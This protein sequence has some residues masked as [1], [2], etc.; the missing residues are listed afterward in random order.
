MAVILWGMESLDV[1][2]LDGKTK[3]AT[4]PA[5]RCRRLGT[6]LGQAEHLARMHGSRYEARRLWIKLAG[7][8][9]DLF[10]EDREE[11]GALL[12][13][14]P[15]AGSVTRVVAILRLHL[16][17][18]QGAA[19]HTQLRAWKDRLQN[20]DKKL[21]EWLR[22]PGVRPALA[23]NREGV[24]TANISQQLMQLWPLGYQC[25][26][27]TGTSLLVS[28]CFCSV[29]RP[30]Y[31]VRP[32]SGKD[33]WVMQPSSPG[34]DNRCPCMANRL[35]ALLGTIERS[36]KWPSSLLEGSTSLLPNPGSDSFRPI[37]VLSVVY[38]LWSKSRL[39]VVVPWLTAWKPDGIYGAGPGA[40]ADVLGMEVA[41]DV[42]CKNFLTAG[43]ELK[44]ATALN[45]T[46]LNDWRA[47]AD[48][49]RH[50]PV[51]WRQKVLALL[52]KQGQFT[53]GQGTHSLAYS[54]AELNK[55]RSAI[56][57]EESPNP[58]S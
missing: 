16:H 52:S 57:F 19:S 39:E 54:D 8:R 42:E 58:A 26:R 35:A 25:F 5:L 17:R 56:D 24:L 14:A 49:A 34:L 21:F 37:S 22:G 3:Q 38:R 1:D 9:T 41:L 28:L 15:C 31:A 43:D 53:W 51:A 48:R 10:V 44:H 30:T 27:S 29:S 55:V 7:V 32:W 20:S 46:R 33:G 4:A 6:A 18:A 11:Y 23:P 12:A 40:S 13:N 2:G 47:T 45:D 50:A 36:G